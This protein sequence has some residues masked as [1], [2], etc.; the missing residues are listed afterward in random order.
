MEQSPSWEA[1]KSSVSQEIPCII[2][3]LQGQYR[4][5][6]MYT[7]LFSPIS[8]TCPLCFILLDLNTLMLFVEGCIIKFIVMKS[9]QHSGVLPLL[10]QNTFLGTHFRNTSAR[11]PSSTWEIITPIQNKRQNY[12]SVWFNPYMLE[13]QTGWKRICT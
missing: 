9:S 6:T 13:Q 11:V 10:G 3:N 5:R 12:S 1:N 4:T 7:T 8:A 2:W